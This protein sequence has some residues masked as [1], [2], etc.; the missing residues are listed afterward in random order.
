[1]TLDHPLIAE[2]YF[3]PRRD[4]P[5]DVIEVPAGDIR[6]ACW[7]RV[8]DPDA[9][10]LVHFHGNGEVIADYVPEMADAFSELGVNPFFA[11]YRGYGASTGVPRMLAM[12][13]DVDA[14]FE[15]VGG[16]R[17]VVYGRSVGS[18]YAIELVHRHPEIAALVLESGIADPLERILLRVQ[19]SEVG[20]TLEE[21]E[22]SAREHLNHRAKLE[23]YPNPVLVLHAEHDHLVPLDNAERLAAWSSGDLRV[24]P[25]GDHNTILAYNSASILEAVGSL[26]AS[27]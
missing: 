19:P 1:M 22:Q 7:R 12:L 20:S 14:I 15:A 13:D 23:G 5:P 27:L 24:F 8:T 10:T 2:R 26:I 21:M 9:P 25:R 3:F 18:I 6:L 4:A 11:E 17:M 16:G